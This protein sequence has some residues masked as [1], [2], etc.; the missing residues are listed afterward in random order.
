MG[1]LKT[2]RNLTKWWNQ[3]PSKLRRITICRF[4][5]SIGAGGVIYFTAL[6]F[7]GIAFTGTQIGLGFCAAA[8]AGTITRLSVGI[9]LDRGIGFVNTL[10]I[11]ALLAISADIV[12]LFSYTYKSYLFGEILIGAAAG[13]Y[14][15]SV[16]YAI[17]LCCEDGNSGKGFALA[18][19]ADAL[20]I[21]LGSLIGLIA[22]NMSYIRSIYVIEISCMCLLLIVLGSNTLGTTK[23]FNNQQ[24]IPTKSSKSILDRIKILPKLIK[25]L[26]PILGISLIGTGI[27]SLM[28]IALQLDLVKGGINRPEISVNSISWIIAYKLILLLVIQW[29]I[30][31]KISELTTRLGLKMCIVGFMIGSLLLSISSYFD[32]GIYLVLLG[33]IPITIAIA[34]FLPTATEAIIEIAPKEYRGISMSIYS[35]CYGISFLV[36]PL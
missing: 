21:C 26:A 6:V 11:A 17:A 10:R 7:N 8:I 1:L 35:Q 18:R 2:K 30:G 20:G 13:S 3:F 14:W 4:L 22:T 12:L 19:S 32:K 24:Y 34:I 33:L 27:L 25:L 28:Q 9:S 16:E 36:I 31:S 15:P 23:L 29:P 5:A